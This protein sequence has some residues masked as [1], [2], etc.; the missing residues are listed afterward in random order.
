PTVSEEQPGRARLD[1]NV[2]GTRVP[3]IPAAVVGAGGVEPG[4]GNGIFGRSPAGVGVSLY[5]LFIEKLRHHL[6]AS[7]GLPPFGPQQPAQARQPAALATSEA[8]E[9]A[10]LRVEVQRRVGVGVPGATVERL[11]FAPRCP[12][13]GE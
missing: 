6:S 13:A 4:V 9:P 7:S 11:T 5:F 2:P 8:V 1:S 10:P 12:D 3:V